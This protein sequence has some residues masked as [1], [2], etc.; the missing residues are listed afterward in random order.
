[1]GHERV[2]FLPKTKRWQDIVASI[3]IV[4][5]GSDSAVASIAEKTL[6]NVKARFLRMHEDEGI[7]AAFGYL[8]SLATS[9]L[10]A[11]KGFA[12]PTSGIEENPSPIR[13]A[14]QLND[15][16]KI[17]ADSLEYA[18]LAC[19]AAADTIVGWTR[20][21][22][23]QKLLFDDSTSAI[24]IWSQAATGKG[25][26]EVSRTFFA[27]FTERYL[28]YFLERE[29]SAQISN[30]E[31]R[32]RF[33]QKMEMHLNSVA[34][35]AFEISKITQSFAAGWFNKH[36]LKQRPSNSEIKGFLTVA[37]GKMH[38]ELQRETAQ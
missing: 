6:R 18:E 17:H 11:T 35:H 26:C 10:P 2:G 8:I 25:F 19:R 16:V 34:N 3:A 33:N 37:F 29:A 4:P 22:T 24:N 14:K 30:I 23:S 36:A 20:T 31:A 15:W 27:K 5:F 28:R 21:H 7:Q 32:D 12:S 9:H 1:M 13:I 38:E